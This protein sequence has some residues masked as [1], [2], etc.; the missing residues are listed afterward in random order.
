MS[1]VFFARRAVVACVGV[2][3]LLAAG[4]APA[5]DFAGAGTGAIADND[6][7]G[8]SV[9]FA[10]S[11]I[12]GAVTSVRL[13]LG[14]THSWTGDLEATLTSPGGKAHLLIFGRTGGSPTRPSA[15]PANLS[16][17]YVFADDAQR[18]WWSSISPL[19]SASTV[20]PGTF[21]TSTGG[22][23]LSFHGGCSTSL[24]GAFN[25]LSGADVNGIWTLKI[26]DRSPLDTGSIDAA[27]LSVRDDDLF[28]DRFER[29]LRGSCQLAQFDYT[30]TGRTSYALVRDVGGELNWTVRSNDGTAS[31]AETTFVLGSTI[32]TPLGGDFDGDGIFDAAVWNGGAEGVAAFQIRRSS[33]PGDPLTIYLGRDGDVANEAGDYDG[34]GL[35]D[36]AVYRDGANAGDPSHTYVRLSGNGRLREYVTGENGA[37]GCGGVDFTGDGAADMLI[38][39]DAG[40]NVG[41]FR[42]YDGPT[43]TLV[44]QFT[45]G[46]PSD[47]IVLGNYVGN[48]RADVMAVRTISGV[49]NWFARD[50]E[51]GIGQ[52]AIQWSIAG[53]VRISGDFDGDG[54]DDV[55]AWHGDADPSLNQFFVRPSATPGT[56]ITVTM[57]LQND[58]PVAGSRTH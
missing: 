31:G 56:P 25:G 58:F 28:R 12:V 27:L 1:R 51:T 14:L 16:G 2:C 26:A 39:S 32:S 33:R 54:L 30:G 44:D 40:N 11:G 45:F 36:V 22:T 53:D 8:R 15:D 17:T 38:Q 48:E 37:F 19:S 55:A 29:P 43:G 21:R 18:D 57:G 4:V 20:A 10:V 50:S 49:R 42:V 41:L 34:D 24:A 52:P 35:D 47:F 9:T 5:N 23:S 6:A 3:V 7:A 13:A 46:T